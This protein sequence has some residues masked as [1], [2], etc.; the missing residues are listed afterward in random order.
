[1]NKINYISHK[2][3]RRNYH[4]AE[5]KHKPGLYEI[6]FVDYGEL[7][8]EINKKA[9]L[10]L[11]GECIIIPGETPHNFHEKEDMPFYFLNI[12]FSGEI[13]ASILKMK[14]SVRRNG[15]DLMKKLMHTSVQKKQYSHELLACCLTEF[16]IGLI[17]QADNNIPE[18]LI[19]TVALQSYQ[20]EIVNRAI[21][22]IS[23]EYHKN[24]DMKKMG[25]AIGISESHLRKLLREETGKNFSTLLREQRIAVAKHLLCNSNLSLE[26]I[27]NS[28]GYRSLSC[29]FKVF[30][31]TTGMSPKTYSSSFGDK[32]T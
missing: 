6:I 2:I 5:H 19:E 4:P 11:P 20:S 21:A 16:L 17:W 12:M 23:N 30:K 26:E 27:A 22:V 32:E 24:L 1:V 7:S 9:I 3:K 14:I 13:P 15:R 28:I 18:R 10:L 31:R 8:F 29:F 25:M